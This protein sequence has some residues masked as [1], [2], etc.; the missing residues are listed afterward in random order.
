MVSVS[1]WFVGVGLLLAAASGSAQQVSQ[2]KVVTEIS[3][4]H[5]TIIA[6]EVDGYSTRLVKAILSQAGISATIEIYP[7]ARAYRMALQQ[8]DTLIYN[9][10]R[11]V[12]RE[13]QFQ[14]IGPV[15]TYRLGF[16]KLA[17]R[18]DIQLKSLTE[19]QQY[20]I[21]VQRHDV[22]ET[23]LKQNG[24][25]QPD[26]LVLAADI[27][28]SW[29]LL[30]HGKVDLIIDDPMAL[31]AMAAHFAIEPAYV[32]F[33]FAIKELEQQTYL[34]ANKTMPAQMVNALQQAHQKVADSELFKKVMRSDFD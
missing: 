30:L 8:P 9:I 31:A 19:A 21:A 13:S 5:Q 2:L 27:T 1:R 14:W 34:A 15:A 18:Q 28:E 22:A 26:Q 25:G 33:E 12:E 32:K 10:A 20:S 16:V 29:Q 7:W 3:P 6:G 11:T 4:P 24:F 23:F 17:H